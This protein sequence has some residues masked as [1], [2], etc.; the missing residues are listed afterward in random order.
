MTDE[1]LL[2]LRKSNGRMGISRQ[3]TITTGYI[4]G[5][6]G[7][8]I[9]EYVDTDS[10]AY[11]RP[12]ELPPERAAFR[13]LLAD[14]PRHPGAG[15]AAWHAD[16]LVRGG[17]DAAALTR[18]C[19]IGGHV[20][21]TPRGGDYDLSNANGR[22]RL[23]DDASDA[24]HEVD[25]S[26][27]RILAQQAELRADGRWAGGRRPFGWRADSDSPGGLVLDEAEAALIRQAVADVLGGVTLTAVARRWNA[28]GAAGRQWTQL[29]VRQ[30]LIRPL[31]AA[32]VTLGGKVVGDGRWPAITDEPT[33]RAVAAYLS[34]PGRRTGPGPEPRHLLTGIGLCGECGSVLSVRGSGE[35]VPVYRCR[36]AT[37]G[38]ASGP[39]HASRRVAPL[40]AY[41]RELAIRRLRRPDA[42]QLLRADHTAER[43]ALLADDAAQSALHDEQWQLYRQRV[44]TPRELAEGRA[45]IDARRAVIR[46]QL[47]ALDAAD[48]LAPFLAN[49][50]TAWEESGARERRALIAGLM[51]VT[52]FPAARGRPPGT[53]RG[54]PWFD[55]S[56]IDVRWARRLPS[57]G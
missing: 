2:Y 52:V 1:Y 53:P 54:A 28:A 16:R 6:G 12:G 11:A 22:K 25:H 38:L 10:T 32:L 40:D 46:E 57:D 7:R 43:A 45:G 5:Q 44:I 36:R 42:A 23:R 49:P 31:N 15:I 17:E 41:A 50:E 4:S 26:R 19:V 21:R 56:S 9:G 47:A 55:V 8:I 13:R 18:A 30:V 37:A 20:I 29:T 39:G 35:G 27:E 34:D 3:R 24:E 14:L 48:A 51:H 33:Y